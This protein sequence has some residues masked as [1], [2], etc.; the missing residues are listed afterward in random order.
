[1]RDAIVAAIRER[2]EGVTVLQSLH[3]LFTER[4]VPFDDSG[5]KPLRDPQRYADFRSFIAAGHASPALRARRV[6][7]AEGW[8]TW[9]EEALAEEMGERE[10]R[11]LAALIIGLVELRDRELSAAMLE[12]AGARTVE[13]RVR[14]LMDEGFGRLSQAFPQ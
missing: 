4:R 2:P 6:A 9:F 12:G 1:V 3:E 11:V 8:T 13:R 5:W 10:A 7:I 14:A